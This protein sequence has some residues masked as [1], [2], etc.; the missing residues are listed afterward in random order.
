MPANSAEALALAEKGDWPSGHVTRTSEGPRGKRNA[1]QQRPLTIDWRG[2]R[3]M[4]Q[5]TTVLFDQGQQIIGRDGWGREQFRIMLN[6]ANQNRMGFVPPPTPNL[7]FAAACGHLLLVD[8]GNQVLA[9]DTL[10]P[11]G[12]GSRVAWQQDLI[13]QPPNMFNVQPVRSRDI[14]FPFAASRSVP[15]V[16][17][18]GPIV[19][20][21]GPITSQCVC[22]AR[23]RDLTALD[24]LTG[25][26]LW[27]RH[28][29]A[30]GS[31]VFGDDEVL[32]VAP[33]DGGQSQVLRTA[34]GELLGTCDVPAI[35]A[36]WTFHGRQVVIWRKSGDEK[37]RLILSD[38]WKQ[39]ETMLGEYVAGSKGTVVGN[40]A[41]AM[42]EPGGRFQM[43]S[44]IDGH[45]LLDESL[46]AEPMLQTIAV[47]ETADQEVLIVTRPTRQRAT[48]GRA[49][50]APVLMGDP[51]SPLVSGHVYAF[52]RAT[53]K[54]V[55]STSAVVEQYYALLGHGQ[56]LP[57]LLFLR[58]MQRRSIQGSGEM[59]SA[60]LCLDRRTGR[61]LLD[62]D[63]N[64]P[65]NNFNFEL[66]G[67]RQAKTVS[68]LLPSQTLTLR[69]TDDPTPPEPPYQSGLA[70]RAPR[71]GA[72]PA[73]AVLRALGS[74]DDGDSPDDDAPNQ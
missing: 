32:I 28:G 5:G 39:Q 59:K 62:E 12:S 37:F 3:G 9:L 27:T 55:W 14:S 10:R 66:N 8:M 58:P 43:L 56:D 23:A 52:S 26:V 19:G 6:E 16:G 46:E 50:A 41:V 20:A 36:R 68:L 70:Q 17:Q 7:S 18:G 35:D 40:D 30:P 24:P 11:N 33:P 51:N 42:F 53:G 74:A 1:Y 22:V 4:L 64:Q 72:T 60:V 49:N 54:P 61:A 65:L 67:D 57:V 45:K 34:D 73:G 25:A 21:V 13:E 63:L 48:E 2:P 69:F 29:L 31:E 47:Q 71:F 38:P 44:L 15:G